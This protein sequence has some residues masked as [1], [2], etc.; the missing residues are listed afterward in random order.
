MTDRK[1]LDILQGIAAAM[2][3][4]LGGAGFAVLVFKIGEPNLC[5]YVSNVDRDAM[6]AAMLEVIARWE[7]R[8]HDAPVEVQ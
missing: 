2:D 5:N 6:K 7:G 8:A 1:T 4:G 3:K